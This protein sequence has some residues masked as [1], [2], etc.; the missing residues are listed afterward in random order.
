VYD[1]ASDWTPIYDRTSLEAFYVAIGT[2]GNQFKNAP[3]AGAFMAAIVA[4]VESGHDHEAEP[5]RHVG[6]YTG[7]RIN[8]GTFSRK[9]P[10]N[11]ASS[12]TVMG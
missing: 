10:V 9:R 4:A 7:A 2:S 1:V 8:L 3:L 12:G 11:T 5:V 6:Q